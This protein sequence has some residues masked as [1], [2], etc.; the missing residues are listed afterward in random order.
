MQWC[1]IGR[2]VPLGYGVTSL[3]GQFPTFRNVVIYL[4]LK[5]KMFLDVRTSVPSYMS[6]LCCF[7][8]SETTHSV[9]RHRIPVEQILQLIIVFELRL[10]MQP[11][12]WLDTGFGS[13]FLS[14]FSF[15]F[16]FVCLEFYTF[17]RVTIT[18]WDLF[19]ASELISHNTCIV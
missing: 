9:T 3:A 19:T 4:S 1:D 18:S 8:T 7:S 5:G 14:S 13:F 16:L 6:E 10:R 11:G 12:T 15:V 17:C 2:S